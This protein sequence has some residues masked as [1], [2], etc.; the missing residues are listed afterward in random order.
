AVFSEALS[1]ALRRHAA[2]GDQSLLFVNRRGYASFVLCRECGHVPRCPNCHVALTLHAP[3]H[4][5]R[6][7]TC[8]L[9]QPAPSSCP[10]CRGVWIRAFGPG[11]QR[12]EETVRALLPTA[13]VARADRDTMAARGAHDR[14]VSDLRGRRI[15]VVVGTQIIGKGLDLPDVALVGVVACDVALHFPDYRAA[16]RTFQQ[17]TQVAGRAGRGDAPGEV[18]FQTYHPSE[19]AIVMAAA[20]DVD[21]FAAIEL[22]NRAAYRYP[23]FE[24]LVNAVVSATAERVAERAAAAFADAVPAGVEVLGPAPAPFAKR[25]GWYRWQ[26]VMRAAAGADVG[27]AVRTARASWRRPPGVRLVV[28]VD[29]MEML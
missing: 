7:H 11:T 28:D 4:V 5:M 8:G 12:V 21:G 29:P 20:H 13:R 25:R 10:R 1:A 15:D 14:L 6:C 2:D 16:E 9:R 23:P 26:V 22:A 3:A 18:I 27:P 17:L 24:R 19:P